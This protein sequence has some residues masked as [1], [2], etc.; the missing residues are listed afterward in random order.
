[1]GKEIEEKIRLVEKRENT[2][3]T[4]TGE[5]LKANE[6][7]RKLQEGVRQEQGKSKLRGQ[8]ATEQ[9]RL[10]V[11]RDKDLGECREQIWEGKELISRLNTKVADLDKKLKEKD[12]KIEELEIVVKTNE[13]VINWLNKQIT[14][15]PASLAP[16][17]AA[18]LPRTG[19]VGSKREGRQ[20]GGITR[21]RGKSPNGT[22]S[23]QLKSDP[24][25]AEAVTELDPKYFISSTPGGTNY[26]QQ[27]P[28]DLPANVRSGAGLV[29]RIN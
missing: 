21:G 6:I 17:P 28:S 4:V 11:E 25:T 12:H 19:P 20:G 24:S 3:K 13:N 14:A 22:V 18:D 29:R 26:R 10:L 7:I 16:G 27:I 9:E 1:M 2:V 15:H 23:Q 5:L 8:I